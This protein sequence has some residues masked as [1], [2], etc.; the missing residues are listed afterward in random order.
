MDC[1]V[2]FDIG[3]TKCA[4]CTGVEEAG[5]PCVLKRHEIATPATQA[6]AME[7]MCAMALDM[8][9]GCRV[10]GAGVS[11]GG[12]LDRARGVLLNPPNLP[13]WS[14]ASWTERITRTLGAPA[15]MEND[16]N[17][18]ALAEWRWGAGQGCRSMAFLTFGTGLG[19][20]LI[21]DGRLY[22]GACGMAG[23]L[24]HWR[25]SDYGPTGYGKEGSFEGFCSGGGIRQLAE[26]LALRERQK[27]APVSMGPGPL[28][29]RVVAEAAGRGD[30]LAL[31]ALDHVARQLG[32]GL[33][34]LVD[35]LNP[36]RIVIGSI[37]ARC[38]GLL[39][40]G[41]LRTLAQEALPASL[42]ACRILPA[43]LGDRIGDYAA[44]AIAMAGA[45]QA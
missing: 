1:W 6:E 21:L 43:A 26:T 31:E 29:A 27:G 9:E 40:D 11:T 39:R 12:P 3:G 23:E 13:G 8:T 37:Y 17:A 44:L 30:P 34:L 33:A 2:G 18:C 10:L 36:E 42:A 5:T 38:E 22:R 20:G 28:T 7:R 19:A 15:F 35:L 4:V 45:E 25:L 32:R 16:A 14:G 41:M 24:G